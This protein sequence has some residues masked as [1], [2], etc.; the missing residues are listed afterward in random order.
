VVS[1]A[2]AVVDLGSVVGEDGAVEAGGVAS[3]WAA[4]SR[5]ARANGTPRRMTTVTSDSIFRSGSCRCHQDAGGSSE[6]IAP[7]C[8]VVRVPPACQR[9]VKM[10]RRVLERVHSVFEGR[11]ARRVEES[12]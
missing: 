5:K 4:S 7:E 2:G 1:G 10:L 8:S 3:P 12:V 11:C 6:F 9:I